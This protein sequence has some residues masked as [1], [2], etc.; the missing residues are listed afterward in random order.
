MAYHV[1]SITHDAHKQ[2]PNVWV[3]LKSL[4]NSIM[5]KLAPMF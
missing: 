2:S 4:L 1:D 3:C 5:Q